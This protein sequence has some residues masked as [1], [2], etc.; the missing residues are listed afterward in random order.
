[1]LNAEG[2]VASVTQDCFYKN[3]SPEERE[4]AYQSNYNFDHP[5]A[6]D[7]PHQLEVLR[8]LRDGA[9]AVAVPTYD[10][11]THSRLPKEH[12]TTILAPEIVIFEGILA[13]HDEDM[14]D[15]FDLKVFVDA[16]AD[17]RLARR[18]KRDMADRGRDLDGILEQY[19][20]F[21]KPATETFVEPT[22]AFA[23]IIVPRGI[24]NSVAIEMLAQHINGH[25]LQREVAAEVAGQNWE[26]MES[27]LTTRGLPK[28]NGVTH[29]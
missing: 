1:M 24:E 8:R 7:W 11:V 23:D 14:R 27:L 13:M 10:F 25:L 5:N 4:E 18:I 28:R 15:L 19:Q 21:V 17:V 12:D 26:Q 6:F 2:R 20:R 16:D 29:A 3:L 22:K 9:P